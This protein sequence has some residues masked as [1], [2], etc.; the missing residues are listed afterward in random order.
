MKYYNKQ[1]LIVKLNQ[2]LNHQKYYNSAILSIFKI[3]S[4]YN[5]VKCHK[6][7]HTDL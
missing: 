4:K 3:K 7:S 1:H 2:N 6:N 5:I